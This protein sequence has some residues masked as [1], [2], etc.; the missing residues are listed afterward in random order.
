MCD[1][2]IR[3]IGASLFNGDYPAQA[4]RRGEDNESGIIEKTA[5]TGKQSDTKK[6]QR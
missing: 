4:R 3:Y 1:E 6:S 5:R 2:E